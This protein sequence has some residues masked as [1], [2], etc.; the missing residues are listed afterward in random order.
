M[1]AEADVEGIA[2][3]SVFRVVSIEDKVIDWVVSSM[4]TSSFPSTSPSSSVSVSGREVSVEG[5]GDG[6]VAVRK[7]P[8]AFTIVELLR[9]LDLR[10]CSV[11]CAVSM[12]AVLFVAV[13]VVLLSQTGR[14]MTVPLRS[15][16]GITTTP[17]GVPLPKGVAA[18]EAFV[19]R[20]VSLLDAE[21][22]VD[23]RGVVNKVLAVEDPIEASGPGETSMGSS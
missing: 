23:G 5:D 9:L 7:R 3:V 4:S 19:E 1:E 13:V 14:A 17:V 20:S 21:V 12:V 22:E 6:D 10:G 11:L 8:V 18:V 15:R 2:F 16:L